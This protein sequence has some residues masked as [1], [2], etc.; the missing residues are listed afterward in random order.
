MKQHAP[1]YKQIQALPTYIGGK[2][3]LLSWI[4]TILAQAVPVETWKELVLVDLFMGGGS[5][6]YWAKAQGFK[7]VMANDI[8]LRSQILGTAFL[9]N[10]RT[11]LSQEDALQLA[12]PLPDDVP[13]FVE[14]HFA[15]NV[16]STRHAKALDQGLYWAKQH[17][18]PTKRALLITVM[19][20]LATE[21]VS[22]ATSLGTSNRPFAEMLDGLRDWSE[23]NPKRFTDGSL[24][25][26][27]EPTWSRLEAK[28]ML[29]NRGVLGGSPVT[30]YQD[31]ALTLLPQL[32]GDILYLDP[33]YAGTVSYERSNE[34]LDALLTGQ[35]EP[36]QVAVSA[37]SKST[38]ALEALLAK[39]DHIPIW[40][41]SYGNQELSR[42]DLEELVRVYAGNRMVL[43]F[44]KRYRHFSHVSKQENNQEVM[45]LAY[46]QKGG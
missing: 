1:L 44:A 39:A 3:Q 15:P 34:V 40:L 20:H 12:Q 18:D 2:R 9:Q 16:F 33:P 28:R 26:L 32:T 13:A 27:C 11:H 46:P 41:L 6:S 30:L 14:T 29:V 22:F 23:L 35:I 4:Q 7:T 8:S 10:Q 21:F 37:F 45:I 36:E 24:K 43:S 42:E 5:V 31:D 25:R 17:P 19:W 38:D